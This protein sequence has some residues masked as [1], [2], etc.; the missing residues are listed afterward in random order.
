MTRARKRMFSETST[1]GDVASL[2]SYMDFK[3][4]KAT[5]KRT[6]IKRKSK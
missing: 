4:R 6:L 1:A 3:K 5:K 2:P